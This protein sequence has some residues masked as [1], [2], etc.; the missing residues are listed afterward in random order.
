MPTP[1]GRYITVTPS[2]AASLGAIVADARS[3]DVIALADGVYPVSGDVVLNLHTPGVT[4]MSASRDASKVVIDGGR[5]YAAREIVQVTASDVTV[6]HLTIRH[7]RDHLVHLYPGSGADIGHITLHGLVLED[8]GQQ[9]LKSNSDGTEATYATA[10]FVDDV[11]VTCSSFVMSEAGRRFVPTNPANAT[12]P[13]YTGGLDAHAAARWTVSRNRFEGL[14]CDNGSLSEHAIHFWMGGRDEVIERNVIVDCARG[15]GLGMGDGVGVHERP[16]ADRPHASAKVAPYAG[17]YGG[18]IRNNLIVASM[19]AYDSGISLEQAL[20]V[21]V[22][23]NTVVSMGRARG[24]AIEYRFSN[25]L[26]DLRNNLA[27]SIVE[28]EGGRATMGRNG[29]IASLS[30]FV[31]PAAGDFRLVRSP[32]EGLQGVA[33]EEAGVGVD[34]LPHPA[35]APALGAVAA[36]F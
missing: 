26:A 3:G 35:T 27:T 28:R 7:A 13:C 15:I 9:F 30:V 1:R 31:N 33:L 24:N 11:S 23:H 16:Y 21:R 18:L 4:L 8:A 32:G 12:Y 6:A 36:P 25:S 22:F 29:L 20:G 19:E 14:Y 17:N 10:H 2:Q 34:G 5:R